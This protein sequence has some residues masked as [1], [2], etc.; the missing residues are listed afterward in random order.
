MRCSRTSGKW[1]CSRDTEDGRTWC[2]V[3]LAINRRPRKAR[4]RAPVPR[5]MLVGVPYE[6]PANL[7]KRPPGRA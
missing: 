6:V 4:E 3:C 7:P 2:A 1:Q 5:D